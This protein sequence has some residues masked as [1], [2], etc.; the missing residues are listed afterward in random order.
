M[1]PIPKY[2]TLA[3]IITHLSGLK[4]ESEEMKEIIKPKQK[5]GYKIVSKSM[6]YRR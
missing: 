4:V 3:K 1:T 2:L 5:E 6:E